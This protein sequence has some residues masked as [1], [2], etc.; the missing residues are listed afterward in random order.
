MLPV[1]SP[2]LKTTL[3]RA[4]ERSC[5]SRLAFRSE[6]RGVALHHDNLA[7][8]DFRAETRMAAEGVPVE[9]TVT[10]KNF[11]S[12]R[13]HP[14]SKSRRSTDRRATSESCLRASIRS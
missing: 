10:L 11:G 14:D 1:I 4:T 5:E 8:L 9:F 13:I 6:M 3:S 12:K 2:W 7:I